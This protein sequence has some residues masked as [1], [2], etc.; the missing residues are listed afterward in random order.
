MKV[1]DLSGKNKSGNGIAINGNTISSKSPPQQHKVLSTMFTTTFINKT[2]APQYGALKS[3]I[4][5][6]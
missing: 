4:L 6:Q 2:Q 5:I 1:K 3:S